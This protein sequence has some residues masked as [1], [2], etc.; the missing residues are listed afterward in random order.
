[1]FWDFGCLV[2]LRVS[3]RF[4][5]LFSRFGDFAEFWYFSGFGCFVAFQV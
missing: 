5:G 4:G 2:F 1:M 3:S